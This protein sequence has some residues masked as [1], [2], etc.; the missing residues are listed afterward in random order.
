[1]WRVLDVVHAPLP[2]PPAVFRIM[3]GQNHSPNC[4]IL[5]QLTGH[6]VLQKTNFG[7]QTLWTR[8]NPPNPP[9]NENFDEQLGLQIR[10]GSVTAP[11]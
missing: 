9:E 5:S 4:Y 2:P 10:V 6:I 11:K 3:L 1:M 8:P 7:C